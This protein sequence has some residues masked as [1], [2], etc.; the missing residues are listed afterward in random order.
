MNNSA[1]EISPEIVGPR[2][3]IRPANK[4]SRTTAASAIKPDVLKVDVGPRLWMPTIKEIQ[5]R[6]TAMSGNIT[7]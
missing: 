7:A 4:P 3:L 5:A 1:F 6:R 2:N